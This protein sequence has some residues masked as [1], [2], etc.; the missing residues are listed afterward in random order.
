MSQITLAMEYIIT[1]RIIICLIFIYVRD[2]TYRQT[3]YR[4]NMRLKI[5]F[6]HVRGAKNCFYIEH[7]V[8]IS[9]LEIFSL[10]SYPRITFQCIMFSEN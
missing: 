6:R 10:S 1:V 5:Q 8:G 9:F 3:T 7:F 4:F 2:V